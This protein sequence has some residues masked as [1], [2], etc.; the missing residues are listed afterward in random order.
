MFDICK[1][2]ALGVAAVAV[3][4][5]TY[6][7]Q[8]AEQYPGF[9]DAVTHDMAVH[10]VDPAPPGAEN[11]SIELHGARADVLMER[12]ETGAVIAPEDVETAGE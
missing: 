1:K 3:A 5:C 6:P 12:Y 4:G 8:P 7:M 10:I 9:G 11:T 2:F